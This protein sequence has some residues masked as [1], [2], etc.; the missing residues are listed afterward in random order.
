METR[1]TILAF[2]ENFEVTATVDLSQVEEAIANLNSTVTEC[3]ARLHESI[4]L[5]ET[6][7]AYDIAECCNVMQHNFDDT[8]TILEEIEDA[9]VACC[10]TIQNNFNDTFTVLAHLD[11]TLAECCAAHQANFDG[12][13]TALNALKTASNNNFN[14]TFTALQNIENTIT[15]CCASLHNDIVTTQTTILEA[16]DHIFV[17]ATVD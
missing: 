7:L 14:S 4:L 2:L 12:T 15:E 6:T 9:L 11:T 10:N 3:C 8:F 17:T 16:L 5:T 1:T 13:F